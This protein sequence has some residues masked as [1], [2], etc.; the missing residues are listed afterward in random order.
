MP[1][2]VDEQW[3][4]VD[5]HNLSEKYVY[6]DD[7]I[8][9]RV[10]RRQATKPG[11][12]TREWFTAECWNGDEFIPREEPQAEFEMAVQLLVFDEGR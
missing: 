5:A 6:V 11:D 8:L 12:L 3:Q 4:Y 9:G 7:L 10:R 1:I 2:H